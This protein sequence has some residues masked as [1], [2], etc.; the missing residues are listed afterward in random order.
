MGEISIDAVLK[1]YQNYYFNSILIYLFTYECPHGKNTNK[2][3]KSNKQDCNLIFPIIMDE[4]TIFIPGRT[5][6]RVTVAKY[7]CIPK[8]RIEGN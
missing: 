2:C 3:T 1:I 5:G 7:G 6:I 8:R 4:L